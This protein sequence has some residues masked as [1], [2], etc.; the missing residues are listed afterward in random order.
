MKFKKICAAHFL[1][2][3]LLCVAGREAIC[4]ASLPQARP[5]GSAAESLL[6]GPG[7]LVHVTVFRLPEMETKVRVTDAGDVTL[8]LVGK[9]HIAGLTPAE[10]SRTVAL[11][12]AAGHYLVDPQV[13]V[14][15]EEYATQTVAIMGEVL[16]P[17]TFPIATPRGVMD[18]LA[19]AGGFTLAADR[20]ITIQHGSGAK[21]EVFLPNNAK[22][23]LA[24]EVLVYPGDLI[25]VPKAGIVYVLGDVMRPGGYVM[26]DDSTLTVLQAVA[27]ASVRTIRRRKRMRWSC[28]ERRR[29]TSKFRCR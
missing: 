28:A 18:T 25:I 19:L 5:T 29:G 20:H 6:I 7:D 14:M 8:P 23:A 15:V 4:Q 24:A 10:A 11:Q 2:S 17:G 1:V 3:A 13:S 22:N 27:M 12:Y 16:R 9:L 21:Q 26:Q